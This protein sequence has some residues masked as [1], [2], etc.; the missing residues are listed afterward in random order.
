MQQTICNAFHASV[1]RMV[2]GYNVVSELN[3]YLQQKKNVV[4]EQ[5]SSR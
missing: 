5:N 2:D 4:N 3:A 1:I